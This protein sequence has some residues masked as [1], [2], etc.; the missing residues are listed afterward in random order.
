MYVVI[1]RHSLN[2]SMIEAAMSCGNGKP[3]PIFKDEDGLVLSDFVF[4]QIADQ[5]CDLFTGYLKLD[6]E[7]LTTTIAN[8]KSGIDIKI[9][10][11]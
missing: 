7:E 11:K 2:N 10:Y 5:Y 3:V 6:L 9:T 4:I 8:I 1:D